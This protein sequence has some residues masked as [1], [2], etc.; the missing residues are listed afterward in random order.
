LRQAKKIARALLFKRKGET[1]E[2]TSGG[3]AN[4]RTLVPAWL[5]C[6]AIETTLEDTELAGSQFVLRVI[7]LRFESIPMTLREDNTTRRRRIFSEDK[8]R[9]GSG[10]RLG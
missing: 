1:R 5:R 9:V 8:T 3:L 2:K 7:L 10:H 4:R 6:Q